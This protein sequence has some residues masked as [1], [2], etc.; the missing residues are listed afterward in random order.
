MTLFLQ[1]QYLLLFFS[2]L[3]SL[4]GMC[5]QGRNYRKKKEGEREGWEE[6]DLRLRVVSVR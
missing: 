4:R 1:G 2:F 6:E 5:W 3:V